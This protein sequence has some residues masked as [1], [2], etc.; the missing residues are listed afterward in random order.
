MQFTKKL[1]RKDFLKYGAILLGAPLL[2]SIN[3]SCSKVTDTGDVETHSKLDKAISKEPNYVVSANLSKTTG[4]NVSKIPLSSI[5]NARK[6]VNLVT[7]IINNNDSF[8]LQTVNV[9]LLN[10]DGSFAYVTGL[11]NGDVLLLEPGKTIKLLANIDRVGLRNR[12]I[13]IKKS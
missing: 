3:S 7:K 1:N 10:A 12:F 9:N 8:K 4:E 13:H 5:T 6:G 2:I 11:A